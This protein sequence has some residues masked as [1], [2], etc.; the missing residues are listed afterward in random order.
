M[1]NPYV[2]KKYGGLLALGFAPVIAFMSGMIFYGDVW[3]SVAMA[4]GTFI[5]FLPLCVML[6]RDPFRQLVEGKGLLVVNLD[7]TGNMTPVICG[8]QQPYVKGKMLNQEFED[9]YDQNTVFRW[10]HAE[11]GQYIEVDGVL[12]IKM[13][14]REFNKHRFGMMNFPTLVY[15]AQIKSCIDKD[16]LSEKEKSAMAE[17]TTLYL[18]RKMEELTTA[19]RDFG[20]HIIDLLRPKGQGSS[21]IWVILGI[22]VLGIIA[23]TIYY[24]VSGSGGDPVAQYQATGEALKAGQIL[25]PSGA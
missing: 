17:H 18:N 24:F 11:K 12:Y 10:S 25:I 4:G 3:L 9:V 19:L 14:S 8:L 2:M 5:V 7:S 23:Y 20:R 13:N 1:L 16:F 22:V 6:L 15:N 21:M